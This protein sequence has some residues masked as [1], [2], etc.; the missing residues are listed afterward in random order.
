MSICFSLFSFKYSFDVIIKCFQDIQINNLN[1]KK[2]F[3]EL[4]K[5]LIPAE[6]SPTALSQ[7]YNDSYSFS[8]VKWLSCHEK[9]RGVN[10]GVSVALHGSWNHCVRK[11]RNSI[12]QFEPPQ[13]SDNYQSLNEAV[14]DL[15]L[16]APCNSVS[17]LLCSV[18]SRTRSKPIAIFRD[19]SPDSELNFLAV[20]W[21]INELVLCV[22][23]WYPLCNGT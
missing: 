18:A 10:K 15:V 1:Q 14:S 11:N 21:K 9:T 13:I 5:W 17:A 8:H 6:V 12:S 4:K 7:K 20:S 16:W 23:S 3:A 19:F 22:A 2:S